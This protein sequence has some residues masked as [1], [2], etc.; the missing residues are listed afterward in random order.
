MSTSIL[1]RSC[2]TRCLNH[3]SSTKCF[4]ESAIDLLFIGP[5]HARRP[6]CTPAAAPCIRP[7]LGHDT[8]SRK[9]RN[10]SFWAALCC[11]SPRRSPRLRSA[12]SSSRFAASPA[13]SFR[14]AADFRCCHRSTNRR[15]SA[16]D[17][18]KSLSN[19][20]STRLRLSCSANLSSTRSVC[21]RIFQIGIVP[22]RRSLPWRSE[23][24]WRPHAGTPD[25][26]PDA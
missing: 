3:R 10:E 21:L 18:P 23:T 8:P 25:A 15:N 1:M 7:A 14:S 22:G 16:S 19:P 6:D 24:D 2:Q 26:P 9:L 4:A 5:R 13:S 17:Q 12:S 11:N 20:S